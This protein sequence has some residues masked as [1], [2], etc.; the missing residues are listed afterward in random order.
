MATLC[1]MMVFSV[2]SKFWKA[3][4]LSTFCTPAASVSL[5]PKDMLRH[6]EE[7]QIR[8]H[9]VDFIS[10]QGQRKSNGIRKPFSFHDQAA[11]NHQT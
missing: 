3:S 9:A 7:E 4:G 8:T 2:S 10:S 1:E 6:V 5:G 11:Q